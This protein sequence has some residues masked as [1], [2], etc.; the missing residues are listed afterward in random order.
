MEEAVDETKDS[1]KSEFYKMRRNPGPYAQKRALD[2]YSGQKDPGPCQFACGACL[3]CKSHA[4]FM[5]QADGIG[6]LD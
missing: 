4:R 2:I 3:L 5:F 1:V 6:Q